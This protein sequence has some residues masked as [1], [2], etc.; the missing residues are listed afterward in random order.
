MFLDNHLLMSNC[1]DNHIFQKVI[2]KMFCCAELI[3][4]VKKGG[5]A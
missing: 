1:V 2:I 4:K 3:G 5:Y